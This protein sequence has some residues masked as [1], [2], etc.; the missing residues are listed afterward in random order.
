MSWARRNITIIAVF[1]T[2]AI[3]LLG[4]VA[5]FGAV[6]GHLTQVSKGVSKLDERSVKAA[7]ER[8]QNNAHIRVL[9]QRLEGIVD[10]LERAVDRLERRIRPPGG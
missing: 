7:Q 9:E 8:H 1:V 4:G 10:R 3:T 5:A 6:A 2:V